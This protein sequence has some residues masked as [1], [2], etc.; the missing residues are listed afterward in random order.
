MG[1]LKLIVT[2]LLTAVIVAAVTSAFWIYAYNNAD[3][4][5]SASG[6]SVVVGSP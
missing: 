6:D 2:N 4:D 3:D 5:V 1:K